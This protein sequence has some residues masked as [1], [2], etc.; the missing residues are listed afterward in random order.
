M[1]S[2]VKEVHFDRFTILT[3]H[4]GGFLPA[5]IYEHARLRIREPSSTT[6]FIH[7]ALAFSIIDH[8]RTVRPPQ[9]LWVFLAAWYTCVPLVSDAVPFCSSIKPCQYCNVYLSFTITGSFSKPVICHGMRNY[10]DFYINHSIRVWWK[11]SCSQLWSMNFI[12]KPFFVWELT[13]A[14]IRRLL[15]FYGWSMSGFM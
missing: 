6:M 15:Y 12:W 7:F 3:E 14:K 4:N 13:R 2:C 8:L 11:C 5:H 9:L 1:N 10:N